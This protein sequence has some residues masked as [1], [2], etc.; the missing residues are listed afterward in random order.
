MT[1]FLILGAVRE[2]TLREAF[3]GS[4]TSHVPGHSWNSGLFRA[5]SGCDQGRSSDN[6]NDERE[7]LLGSTHHVL[8]TLLSV[9]PVTPCHHPPSQSLTEPL[10]M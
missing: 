8:P 7:L 9:S 5:F 1:T 4:R 2:G 6:D 10:Y 3:W